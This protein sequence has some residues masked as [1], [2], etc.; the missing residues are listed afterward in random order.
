[1]FDEPSSLARELLAVLPEDL[2]LALFI[3]ASLFPLG[4]F[5]QCGAHQG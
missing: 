5:L 3:R 2:P 4:E 1:L